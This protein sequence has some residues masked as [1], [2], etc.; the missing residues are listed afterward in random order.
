M[1]PLDFTTPVSRPTSNADPQSSP[2]SR[3]RVPPHRLGLKEVLSEL[4]AD[5]LLA[6]ADADR[7][8]LGIRP[9]GG[10]LHPLVVIANKQLHQIRPPH[11]RTPQQKPPRSAA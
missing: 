8:G 9:E 7:A 1:S 2:S 10:E 5:G 11:Q 4:V 3:P 6:K